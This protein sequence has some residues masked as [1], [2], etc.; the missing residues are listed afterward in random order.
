VTAAFAALLLACSALAG[1]AGYRKCSLDTQSCLDAMVV[2]LKGRGWLGI[3]YDDSQG[4]RNFR[5]TRV[6]PGS[7]A[8]SA[9]FKAG[10]ILVSVKGAKFADNTEDRCVTCDATK[11]DWKPGARLD[12]V[13][14][15]GGRTVTLRP[16]LA[17]LPS[18]AMAQMIGMHMLE[19]VQASAPPK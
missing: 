9:G 10:D 7:P 1:E 18:D 3:E 15:R 16:T 17:P 8:E 11:D 13:V 12:Y 19:H 5:V 6:V 14:R 4:P 2:K